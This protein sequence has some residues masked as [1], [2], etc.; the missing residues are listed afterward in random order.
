MDYFPEKKIG[1]RIWS[2]FVLLLLIGVCICI[3][4]NYIVSHEISW[5]LYSAGAAALSLAIATS[6]TFGG[7]H[8]LLLT[9]TELAILIMPFRVYGKITD[10]EI[11]SRSPRK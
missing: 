6:L 2:G 3:L 1:K 8:R 7:E 11:S 4:V 5:S 10:R 9:I